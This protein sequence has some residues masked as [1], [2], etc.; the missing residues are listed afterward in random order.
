M[1]LT[2]YIFQVLGIVVFAT[3]LCLPSCN[4]SKGLADGAYVYEGTTIEVVDPEEAESVPDFS[5]T[6][7]EIPRQGTKSG[8]LN[9]YTGLYNIYAQTGEKG[10]KH[11]VKY[12]LG[13]A[14]IA[15]ENKMIGRTEAKLAYYL[16]GRG[17][18]KSVARCDSTAHGRKASV[19]CTVE[20]GP[21]FI[22]DS[23]FFPIDTTY[24]ALKVDENIRCTIIREGSYY[25]RDALAYERSRTTMVANNIGFTDFREENIFFHVDTIKGNKVNIYM[26]ILQPSDSTYHSRYT[27]EHIDIFPNHTI[28][29]QSTNTLDTVSLSGKMSVIESEYYINHK[30]LDRL[31]VQTLGAYHNKTN[32]VKSISRLLDIGLFKFVNINNIVQQQGQ[33]GTLRQQILL[34]PN[35]MQSISGELELN[36]RSGNI[37]GVGLSSSYTHRNLFNGAEQLRISASGLVETQFDRSVSFINSSDLTISADL[38]FP[39]II[40]PGFEVKEQYNSIPRTIANASFTRQRRTEFYTLRSVS[41]KYGFRWKPNSRT[42]HQ[43]YPIVLSQFLVSAKSDEFEQLLAADQRLAGSFSNVLVAGIE[44]D[45]DVNTQKG[46][47]DEEYSFFHAEVETSGHLASLLLGADTAVPSEI[48]NV[49]FAQFT[50]LTVDWRTYRPVV[51]GR[52]AT[53]VIVG[54][55]YSY[56]NSEELPYIKQYV[57]G[58]SNSLRAFRL[59]GI[60]PGAFVQDPATITVFEEQFVD[61]TG[62]I[63]LEFN[64]EYRFPIFSYLKGAVFADAGNV[65]V[66][67]DRDKRGGVFKIDSFYK[68]IALGTGVGFRLDFE[69][70]LLRLDLSFPLR[71]PVFDEG[72]QWV[73]ED[74]DPFS[75]TWRATNLRYNLGIGYPF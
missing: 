56:G 61:Q 11:W 49:P 52:L 45:Y 55:G 43:F 8:L 25:K 57:S 48:A 65:W 13:K 4:V 2:K 51:G 6:I 69:F 30:L 7:R 36:N 46:K 17:F 60:G 59:R 23:V 42:N 21:Q 72:F 71:R 22:I 12:K 9:V 29:R 53:R 47:S 64:V 1:I 19:V 15:Y 74:I 54:A 32:Q 14:P 58:G 75:S 70:F 33:D 26:E 10:F 31:I 18:F 5:K 73:V 63:K 24:T 41:G 34:T 20:L 66:F 62:D 38:T 3:I 68:Q 39:R 44:Y 40:L 27:L 37:F 16:R 35:R 67:E 50:K 28:D